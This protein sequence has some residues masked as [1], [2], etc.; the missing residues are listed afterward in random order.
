MQER[1]RSYKL[2]FDDRAAEMGV[3]RER[4]DVD[5]SLKREMRREGK[6]ARGGMLR[7]G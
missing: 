3:G 6:N 2:Y 4:V 5:C 7:A 1:E